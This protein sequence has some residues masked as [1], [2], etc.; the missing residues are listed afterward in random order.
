MP[1]YV[2]KSN[3]RLKE[4]LQSNKSIRKPT[5]IERSSRISWKS[6]PLEKILRH[7]K[8]SNSLASL[9]SNLGAKLTRT[10]KKTQKEMRIDTGT[11]RSRTPAAKQKTGKR[12]AKVHSAKQK[13]RRSAIVGKSSKSKS[14]NR[15]DWV[16]K[17][18][19]GGEYCY[20]K[21]TPKQK[22][23]LKKK[24][25][26][27]GSSRKIPQ[28]LKKENNNKVWLL[29]SE[30]MQNPKFRKTSKNFKTRTTL[31]WL[32]TEEGSNYIKL[33]GQPSST[34]NG[35]RRDFKKSK[36]EIRNGTL[37]QLKISFA[38][39]SETPKAQMSQKHIRKGFNE[40]SQENS[41]GF[42]KRKIMILNKKKAGWNNCNK[43]YLSKGENLW[44]ENP[45]SDWKGFSTCKNYMTKSKNFLGNNLFRGKFHKE[46]K[47][48]AEI[49]KKKTAKIFYNKKGNCSEY[50]YLG[51]A[52]DLRKQGVLKK[53]RKTSD[54][55]KKTPM[56]SSSKTKTKVIKFS[57]TSTQRCKDISRL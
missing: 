28:S 8:S 32:R 44:G 10:A 34:K 26:S 33:P 20:Y 37:D 4:I 14:K 27:P 39:L 38:D 25:R 40:Y 42:P 18:A 46:E 9:W 55:L 45:K 51:K 24:G 11:E 47:L 3:N 36:K 19:L 56:S 52:K 7:G 48:V 41:D 6:R 17:V 15:K 13:P 57:K 29:K 1:Y 21:G 53:G 50:E 22:S 35:F 30:F 43:M 54:S 23:L 31:D 16:S 12:K 5:S 49:V 2:W